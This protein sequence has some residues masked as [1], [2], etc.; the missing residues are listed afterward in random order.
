MRI[1]GKI[2]GVSLV[3]LLDI[4]STHNFID[5]ALIPSLHFLV[6][7]SQ[8]LEV[9]VANGVVVRTQG[10][11]DQVLVCIQREEFSI[12]FRVLPLGGCDVVLGT[13]WLTTLGDIQWNF[14][15]LTMEF[16]HKG[17]KV[18]LQGLK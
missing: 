1:R 3:V 10:F 15:F 14:Q 17:H 4:G 9:K 12:P 2:N 6:D 13:Q 11:C 8:T 16:C 7:Q 5:A 18:M